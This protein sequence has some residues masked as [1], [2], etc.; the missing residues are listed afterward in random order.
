[1]EDSLA[2]RRAEE[3]PAR[4]IDPGEEGPLQKAGPTTPMQAGRARAALAERDA[5]ME[6]GH[7][8]DVP[9]L[10]FFSERVCRGGISSLRA[11]AGEAR[12]ALKRVCLRDQRKQQAFCRCVYRAACK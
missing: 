7:G 1:M 2:V 3:G 4:R 9:L 11:V 12:A 8:M 5:G 10:H 6:K